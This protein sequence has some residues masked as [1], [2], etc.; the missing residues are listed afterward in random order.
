MEAVGLGD[1]EGSSAYTTTGRSCNQ[2][3]EVTNGHGAFKHGA[4]GKIHRYGSKRP[5][6]QQG[7]QAVV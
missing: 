6:R 3:Q 2:D 4:I 1:L 7:L 5:S